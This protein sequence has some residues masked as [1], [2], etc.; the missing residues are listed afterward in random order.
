MQAELQSAALLPVFGAVKKVSTIGLV[1]AINSQVFS[2]HTKSHFG[3]QLVFQ[4]PP[5]L[6]LQDPRVTVLV[7]VGDDSLRDCRKMERTLAQLTEQNPRGMLV[8]AL[9]VAE[10][11][12]VGES[13]FALEATA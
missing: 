6:P 7:L 4:P 10:A 1:D 3:H 13:V 9:Q 12:L 2:S 11:N 8:L 5:P